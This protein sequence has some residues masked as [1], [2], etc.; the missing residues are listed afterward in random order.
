MF[1]GQLTVCYQYACMTGQC[2]KQ[3]SKNFHFL[4]LLGRQLVFDWC[5]LEVDC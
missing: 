5:F 3:V 1:K 4:V 2:D